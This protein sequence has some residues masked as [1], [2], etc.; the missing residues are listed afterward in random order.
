MT[1]DSG[2]SHDDED[3]DSHGHNHDHDSGHQHDH[4]SGYNHDHGNGAKHSSGHGHDSDHSHD[5]DSDHSHDHNHSHDH[6]HPHDEREDVSFGVITVSSSRTL[7]TDESGDQLVAV[8]ESDGKA[9]TARDLVTD[10]QQTIASAVLS[11]VGDSDVDV[12]VL[13]GGT[14]LSP[15]DVTVE[16]VR[17]LFEQE[18]PGFGEL[19]RSLSYEEVGPPAM[20]SRAVAGTVDG[21]PVFCLPG[22][23]QA[24]TFGTEE[25]ILPNAGHILSLTTEQ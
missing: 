9:V 22:S 12:V 4:D 7:E 16:A 5:H 25:L 23:T 11:F 24:A 19:F 2:N 18:I 13:T 20:L 21:V 1:D 10:D 3:E 8:I 15:E 6:S 14:G 17:P